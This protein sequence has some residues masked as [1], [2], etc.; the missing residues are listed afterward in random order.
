MVIGSL[1]MVFK[2][3]IFSDTAVRKHQHWFNQQIGGLCNIYRYLYGT[4]EKLFI[5]DK[6]NVKK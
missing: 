2:V 3:V 4:Q 1:I 6:K 5:T